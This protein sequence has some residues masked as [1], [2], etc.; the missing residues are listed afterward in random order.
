MHRL[1]R[2]IC[3]LALL[4]LALAIALAAKTREFTMPRAF[5]ANT[6][7]ARDAHED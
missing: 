5:H 6:Y 1:V 7:P 2:V 4:T 3:I